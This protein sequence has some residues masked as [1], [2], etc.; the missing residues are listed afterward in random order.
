MPPEPSHHAFSI[1]LSSRKR[2]IDTDCEIKNSY[3][4]AYPTSEG[5]ALWDTGA[6]CSVIGLQV[7]QPLGLTP[8]ADEIVIGV[9][10]SQKA[11]VYVVDILLPNN[12]VYQN[13]E[14]V[15]ADIGRYNLLVGMDIIGVGDFS[16][17]NGRFVSYCYPSL[18]NPVDFAEKAKKIN[19]N[20]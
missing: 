10:G 18:E 8:V 16:I 1:D 4:A 7:V 17:C 20:M 14:V 6:T 5:K 12:I 3:T 15:G 9:H 11:W 2:E 19:K 13:W